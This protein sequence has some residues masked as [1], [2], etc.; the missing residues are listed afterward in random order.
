ML[1]EHGVI[2]ERRKKVNDLPAERERR[3]LALGKG[4]TLVGYPGLSAPIPLSRWQWPRG[5]EAMNTL[6]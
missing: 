6:E 4:A 5:N 1:L 2:E 3:Q